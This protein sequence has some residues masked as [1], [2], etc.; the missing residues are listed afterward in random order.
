MELEPRGDL[1]EVA[2]QVLDFFAE[3]YPGGYS[4]AQLARDVAIQVFKSG[5]PLGGCLSWS[6]QPPREGTSPPSG[7]LPLPQWFSA[8][9]VLQRFEKL[10]FSWEGPG[11]WRE[12]GDTRSK[13]SKV[14][15]HEGMC[16]WHGLAVAAINVMH[17]N[18]RH[19][20]G[21]QMGSLASEAQEEALMQIW[22]QV[23]VFVDEKG[24]KGVPRVCE[25]DW[26][27]KIDELRTSCDGR[28]VEKAHAI[29]LDQILPGLPN[30]GPTGMVKLVDVLP[31]GLAC[32]LCQPE[33]LLRLDP[34]GMPSKPRVY[35]SDQEWPLVVNALIER[36]LVR[37]VDKTPKFEGHF[38]SNG[39]CGVPRG[40][41]FTDSGLPVL[42]IIF[43]LRATNFTMKQLNADGYKLSGAS[44]LQRCIHD[45]GEDLLVSGEDLVSSFFLF[46]LP[47]CWPEYMTLE[48]PVMPEDIGLKGSSRLW[49]GLRVLP[50]GWRSAGSI[51]Q[52]ALWELSLRAPSLEGAGLDKLVRSH[53][54]IHTLTY[55]LNH[56][57]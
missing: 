9:K 19:P 1:H 51:M 27:T 31:E 20:D 22:K 47:D 55:K 57:R 13:A 39:A 54:R 50:V 6:I 56:H 45:D 25:L 8:V 49:V 10:E 44:S 15:R 24:P 30:V 21:P 36:G 43:D 48:K 12:R 37:A 40:N 33:K 5:T 46:E 42:R 34:P 14:L 53:R 7:L 3:E 35:C 41:E 17:G 11:D 16:L 23:E 18:W 28:V 26:A 38:L 32:Q 52:A 29:T 2:G 4:A